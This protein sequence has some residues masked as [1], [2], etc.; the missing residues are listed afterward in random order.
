MSKATDPNTPAILLIGIVGS[1]GL[2]AI[3]VGLTAVYQNVEYEQM[4]DKVYDVV[5]QEL[6]QLRAKQQAKINDYRHLPG[7]EGRIAL[8]IERA[9]ELS[10]D[11]LNAL[12]PTP[13]PME[14]AE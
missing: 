5:P 11:E 9:M 1:I 6:A 14:A 7:D 12:L 10:V 8:P 13:L 4:Q 2:F 3:V